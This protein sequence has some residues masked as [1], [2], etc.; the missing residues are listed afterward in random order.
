[1]AF[2]YLLFSLSSLETPSL[3]LLMLLQD[4]CFRGDKGEENREAEG[5]A[6]F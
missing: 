1:M 4:F 5:S 3:D 2:L 6:V